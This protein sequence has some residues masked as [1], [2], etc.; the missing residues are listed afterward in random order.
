[1][2]DLSLPVNDD[3]R[4]QSTDLN[5]FLQGN[6]RLPTV[7]AEMGYEKL[8]EG[9]DKGVF[10]IMGKQDTICIFPTG[11]GKTA[12]FVIPA[13]CMNWG[14]LV[15]CPLKALMRDQVKQLQAMGI[16]ALDISSDNAP[17][18][19][20]QAMRDWIRGECNF[21]YV[22]P[23]RLANPEFQKAIQRRPP[24]MVT[25]DEAHTLSAWTDSFR[26]SYVY[27]GHLIRQINPKVVAAFT[28]TFS[29][30]VEKDV[31]RVLAIP[32]A[33][34]IT[35]YPTRD[36]LKL[37]SSDWVNNDELA[38]RVAGIDGSVLI[39]CGT[40]KR[41]VD[42]AV[43][44]NKL[45]GEPVAYYHAGVPEA[46]K[47]KN[48]DA[49]F[50]SR[51]RVMCA[52][53][54]FGMGINMASIRSVI[55]VMFPGDPEALAQEIGRAGRDGLDAWCHT[56][57]SKDALRLQEGFIE[58]GNPDESVYRDVFRHF[59]NR[60]DTD[61][62]FVSSPKE[63]ETALCIDPRYLGAIMQ[64]LSGNL[65][66]Q[67][68]EVYRPH[69]VR[70]TNVAGG[71][72]SNSALFQKFLEGLRTVGTVEGPNYYAFDLDIMADHM[73]RVGE[74]V[75]KYLNQWAQEKLVE[76][77]APPR[78]GSY[79]IVGDLSQIDFERLRKK[80]QFA[81]S[82]LKKVQEYFRVPDAQKQAFLQ[83]YLTAHCDT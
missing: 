77:E 39:Y 16:V 23:E 74:T 52:T 57:E 49:F 38:E 63:L 78:G 24:D 83:E 21:L 54:A 43:T 28:A 20:T 37:S 29:R 70:I 60:A 14:N 19:N 58:Y 18:V 44:L 32:N 55:H 22:A 35:H 62:C 1:M 13:L 50:N 36:N 45:L 26:H 65:V 4:T 51:M 47:K 68:Q 40:Q 10:S 76:Y 69:R 64:G 12:T 33:L 3:F 15:F 56:Y 27:I 67:K 71:A 48:Q 41:T 75:R 79:K 7:L 30:E 17:H 53:N 82:K 66:I 11:A 59:R 61:S 42:T 2:H 46:Q 6:A 9:Q 80:K 31:R 8:R 34:K 25:I 5:S 72:S 81:W 73:S